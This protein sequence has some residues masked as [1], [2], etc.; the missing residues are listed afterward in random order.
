MRSHPV[1]LKALLI[2]AVAF[3]GCSGDDIASVGTGAL[4]VTTS[5]SGPG[6]DS[7]G[8]TI[9]LDGVDRGT[10]A[11]AATLELT[12]LAAGDHTLELGGVASTCSVADGPAR[13]ALVTAGDTAEVAFAVTCSVVTGS[14][15]VAVSTSGG[16][17]DPDGYAVSLDG[18]PSGRVEVNGS[19]AIPDLAAGNH[20]VALSGLAF[21]CHVADGDGPREGS[22]LAGTA[23]RVDF[24]VACTPLAPWQVV[25]QGIRPGAD[26]PDHIDKTQWEVFAINPDGS[27]LT[28]LSRSGLDDVDPALSPDHRKVAF[29]SFRD[30][31]PGILVVNVDGTGL[32]RLTATLTPDNFLVWSPD[33]T[34]IAFIRGSALRVINAD[35]TGELDLPI[36]KEVWPGPVS[37]S[38]DGRLIAI[39]AGSD[40]WHQDIWAVHADG[41]GSTNLTSSLVPELEPAWS[42]DGT[43]LA[44]TR[45]TVVNQ[46]LGLYYDDVWL[47]NA[48][49]SGQRQLTHTQYSS[50]AHTYGASA[51]AWSPDGSVILFQSD[52][53]GEPYDLY[54][55]RPDG[56]GVTNLTNT[57]GAAETR[58]AWSSDGSRIV[59]QRND[60]LAYGEVFVMNV[61]GSGVLNLSNNPEVDR[62]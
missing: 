41:T 59:F 13:T 10:I 8:Y 58:A 25:F 30:L 31:S 61:D 47:M 28:D 48:D 2:A 7:D 22:V 52:L 60:G 17:L 53:P 23:V 40:A 3:A 27:G 12:D 37:W 45:R 32:T 43:R 36:G 29:T 19:L 21:N 35:G 24:T 56:S 16:S 62:P 49:G 38:P 15:E 50:T 44:F 54:T 1:P 14:M 4:K 46:D 26:F 42:P 9:R 5:S 18:R 55:I 11:Q 20:A 34:R 51:P 39:I 57:A 33:G 6:A